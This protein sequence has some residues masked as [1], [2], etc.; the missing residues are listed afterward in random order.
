MMPDSIS[1]QVLNSD[2]YVNSATGDD[3]NDGSTP[4]TAFKTL[5]KCLKAVKNVSPP[6]NGD[7]VVHIS[8]SFP[9]ERLDIT[10]DHAGSGPTSRVVFRG[11]GDS[12]AK[13]GGND[14]VFVKVS[15]LNSNHPAR[16]A[17]TKT[18]ADLSKL[19]AAPPP[20]D[21]PSNDSSLRWPDGDC[22]DMEGYASPP[23]L[24]IN[25][26]VQTRSRIPNL[27]QNVGVMPEMGHVL[28]TWLRTRKRDT[29]GKVTYKSSDEDIINLASSDSWDS[30]AVV[31]HLFPL[32]DWFDARVRVGSRDLSKKLFNTITSQRGP[33]DPDE[34]N[35]FVIVPGS[36]YYLEGAIEYLDSPGEYHVSLGETD[37]GKSRGWTLYYPPSGIDMNSASSLKSSVLSVDSTPFINVEG[38][39]DYTGDDNMYVTFQNL[40]IEGGRRHLA[41]IYASSVD[42]VDCSFINAGHDAI[43]VYSRRVSIQNCTFEGSGGSSIQMMD[44]RDMDSDGHGYALLESEHSV[45]DS[46]VSDFSSTCRHYSEGVHLSGYGT[47]VTNNHFRSSNMA[48]IDV[49]G[50][51]FKILHNVFSHVSDGSYDDGAI[52]WVADSPMER[53]TEVAYNVFFRN[54]VTAEPCNAET[55]CV[56]SDVYMDDMAG[57]MT[58]HGNIFLKDK[59]LQPKPPSNKFAKINWIAVFV[60]GGADVSIYE[61]S[62]L[63]P[64]DDSTDGAIYG[65]ASPLYAQTSGGTL[66]SDDDKCGH[67]ELC[68]NSEFYKTMIR[69]KY[70][71]PP[72]SEAFPDVLKYNAKPSGSSNY[73]CAAESSCPVAAW[74]QTVT[75]NAGIG[76]NRSLSNRAL[77][78]TDDESFLNDGDEYVEGEDVPLRSAA[79]TEHGNMLNTDKDWTVAEVDAIEVSGMGAVLSLAEQVGHA[80]EAVPPSCDEGSRVGSARSKLAGRHNNPC[81]I[82]WARDGMS[83]CDP[84]TEPDV[85]C[86]P[87]DMPT[88]GLCSCGDL[89]P[90]SPVTP[91]PTPPVPAVPSA[92]P[93][94]SPV[95]TIPPVTSVVC[96][97]DGDWKLNNKK[98]NCAWAANDPTRRCIRKGS[99]DMYT[100]EACPE[101]CGVC[102]QNNDDAY[103]YYYR[104]GRCESSR[105]EI[106]NIDDARGCWQACD[107]SSDK[108]Q[109]AEFNEKRCFCQKSCPC[110]TSVA[111]NGRV[112]LVPRGFDLPAS[113]EAPP[114]SSPTTREPSPVPSPVTGG[115]CKDDPNWKKKG[116]TIT[117]NL[118]ATKSPKWCNK[119][120]S[121]DGRYVSEAC[122][123]ACGVCPSGDQSYTYYSGVGYCN[124]N[125][126][127]KQATSPSECWEKCQTVNS[128]Y[129]EYFEKVCYCQ[130][131]CP[132]MDDVKSN[133][134]IT[135]APVGFELPSKCKR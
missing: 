127:E 17:A 21:F 122:P 73:Y 125:E 46:L 28:D 29:G 116:T 114:V 91:V 85:Q 68:K 11:E 128:D 80:G 131:T 22:R 66:W 133:G 78:P 65:D 120:K 110:M 98:Q 41:H 43:E 97:D 130:K 45:T 54:G 83:S 34:G 3:D 75:C 134:R 106:K 35:K 126:S 112:T 49:V 31:V 67:T 88:D 111:N 109:Y 55:S 15:D 132:C 38:D 94:K 12:G 77:W 81:T 44:D 87:R 84:C 30:G 63:G 6:E 32:Y 7:L 47:I 129:V 25:G 10:S 2:I 100:N 69:F 8:G 1:R 4:E 62:F 23:V 36:R 5:S 51:G 93:T 89:N 19:W 101:S 135:L 13:M 108:R 82:D 26:L 20:P 61:N 56:Q 86:A 42:I 71:Q 113:C 123:E 52:H 95:P 99:D 121:A 70:D 50:G 59:V 57:A 18:N 79:L 117:C 119:Q 115:D 74:N 118:V 27:P 58:I 76:P 39:S 90:T 37:N 72:W 102:P 16:I 24:S 92:V 104:V 53:G 64:E 124:G 40:H 107:Q 105:K 103:D 48:A 9:G 14:L 33:G 60:N 96:E